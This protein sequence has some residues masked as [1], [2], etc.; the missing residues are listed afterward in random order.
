MKV[1][2]DAITPS[3]IPS[4]TPAPD[5][6]MGYIDGQ[7]PSYSDMKARFPNAIPVSISTNPTNPNRLEAQGCDGEE[8]DYS[9]PEAAA[10]SKGKLSQGV[11]PFEYCSLSDWGSY[12]QCCIDIGINPSQVDWLIAAYPGNGANVYPGSIGHQYADMGSYDLSVVVDGWVPGRLIHVPANTQEIIMGLPTSCSDT[13][14]VNAFIRETYNTYSTAPMTT[15]EQDIF[16][17]F[18][19]LPANQQLWGKNGYGGNPDLLLAGVVDSINSQGNL[20][21][22]RAGSV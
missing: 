8:G 14:A 2:Y 12:Q 5:Y 11:V 20:R 9:P 1:M 18:Y 22:E 17:I 21:S 15:T 10:F 16:R 4:S 19:N 3:S 13:G 7:W 6:A